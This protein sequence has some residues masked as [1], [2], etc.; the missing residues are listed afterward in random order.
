MF[1][2]RIKVKLVYLYEQRALTL[3]IEN[4]FLFSPP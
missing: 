4:K 3:S 1:A 2:M